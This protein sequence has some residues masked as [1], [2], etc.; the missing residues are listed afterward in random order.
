M[1]NPNQRKQAVSWLIVSVIMLTGVLFIYVG[2]AL[3]GFGFVLI[4]GGIVAAVWKLLISNEPRFE[5]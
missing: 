4:V 2:Q 5:K 3:M 1:A